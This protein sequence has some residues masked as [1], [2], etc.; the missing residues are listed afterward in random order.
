MNE[1]IGIDVG[2]N[3]LA[4]TWLR[5]IVSKRIKTKALK[6]T[7]KGHRDLAEWLLKNTKETPENIIITL[8][9]TNIYHEALM[10]FLHNKG[11]KIQ[12]ANTGKAKKYAESINLVH[13][14]DKSDGTMLAY[15]GEA[16]K[17]NLDL[18]VPES[19]EVRELKALMKRLDA[20]NKD[21]QRELNRL[22]SSEFG[23][24]SERVL[25]SLHN[26]IAALD[27]E[28][29]KLTKEID[30]HIDGNPALNK[31]RELLKSIHGIG[32]VMSRELVCLFASKKFNTAKQAAAYLGLIPRLKESGKL[33]GRTVL[34]KLGPA[35]IR[36]KLYMAAVCASTYNPDI[37]AQK[38][39]LLSAGKNKMQAL[40][41]AMRKLIQICFGVVK[42][43]IE[44]QSQIVLKTA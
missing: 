23:L 11:F 6:N 13:K 9:P 12:L 35:H 22:E 19:L 42:H 34:T 41:A 3:D 38:E 1:Y 25:Q 39:R 16:Q 36:A 37:K 27:S 4:T 30:D 29:A 5:D 18:W 21:K 33:R 40:G 8:E 28:I 10:Y 20:L 31:N 44:Y 2:K 15:Y 32:D 24:V 26:I 17:F 7:P 14:T 43:Q